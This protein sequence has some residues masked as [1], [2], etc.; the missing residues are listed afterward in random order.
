M[1]KT[2]KPRTVNGRSEDDRKAIA[3]AYAMADETGRRTLLR[4][5]GITAATAK[6][7]AQVLLGGLKA[8]RKLAAELSAA[9]AAPPLTTSFV[10]TTPV[11][12]R[13]AT[14]AR[15]ERAAA[16]LADEEREILESFAVTLKASLRARVLRVFEG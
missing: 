16:R 8:A 10:L 15:L 4:R 3:Q 6:H 1:A 2:R 7:W 9:P 12:K 5:H 11:A 14:P 13:R